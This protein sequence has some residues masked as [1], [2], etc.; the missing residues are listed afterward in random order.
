MGDEMSSYSA[1]IVTFNLGRLKRA[2]FRLRKSSPPMCVP[3]DTLIR[4][5]YSSFLFYGDLARL[6]TLCFRQSQG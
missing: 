4:P 6:N 1:L 3:T 2:E 5:R